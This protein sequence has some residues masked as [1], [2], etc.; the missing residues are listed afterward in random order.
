MTNSIGRGFHDIR[1][2]GSET[3]VEVWIY[4]NDDG[5]TVMFMSIAERAN[6]WDT[7]SA[8]RISEITA[9]DLPA[10]SLT[11]SYKTLRRKQ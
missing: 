3:L 10:E 11:N 1:E 2:D 4:L 7:W 9:L 8:P 6:K 5:E